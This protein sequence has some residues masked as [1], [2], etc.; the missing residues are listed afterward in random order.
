MFD[1]LIRVM[2]DGGDVLLPYMHGLY[3]ADELARD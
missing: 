1:D 3:S 2:G